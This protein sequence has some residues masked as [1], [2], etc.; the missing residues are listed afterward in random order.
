MVNEEVLDATRMLVEAER[1]GSVVTVIQGEPIG[2]K[3]VLDAHG[4]L[5]AG[6]LPAAIVEGVVADSRS[7][8]ER[9]QSRTVEYGTHDVFIETL[10]PPPELIIF[11]AVHIAQ[12]LSRHAQ[13]LGFRVSV[14]DVRPAFTTEER[15]PGARVLPG[16]PEEVTEGM[17]VDHRTFIVLLSHDPR[18]EDPV[19]DW[20][21]SGAARYIGAMGSRR[22]H[23]ARVEKL[24]ARG[25]TPEQVARIH[26]PV[27]LDIGAETSGETAISILAEMI[28]VRYGSGTGISLRGRQGRIHR[29]RTT[30]EGDA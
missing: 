23:A 11:G 8:M 10:A 15:F 21:L 28:H 19:L 18:F 12:E 7:L 22:T 30:D 13:L 27:G 17:L 26:G 9:E 4:N 5:L 25:H 29:Q 3:A 2:R 20:A 1:F 16:W 14:S 6:S 24:L